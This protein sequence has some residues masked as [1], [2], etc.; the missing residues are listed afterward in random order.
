MATLSDFSS[1]TVER[2]YNSVT[3][4]SF[5]ELVVKYHLS[6]QKDR[7]GIAALQPLLDRNPA[8]DPKLFRGFDVV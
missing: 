5:L 1:L 7:A 8:D 3:A 4:N 6:D 2:A